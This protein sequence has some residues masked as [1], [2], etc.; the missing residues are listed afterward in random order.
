MPVCLLVCLVLSGGIGAHGG[1]L[2]ILGYSVSGWARVL[3]VR[4][5]FLVC[6]TRGNLVDALVF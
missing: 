6:R 1:P 3:C 2:P 5:H 4:W